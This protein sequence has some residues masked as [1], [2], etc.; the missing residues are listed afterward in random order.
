MITWENLTVQS[1]HMFMK[2]L[3]KDDPQTKCV[4]LRAMCGVF[5]AHPRE[6]L[7]LNQSGMISEVMAPESPPT[8]QLEALL[9]W[10]EILLVSSTIRRG[11]ICAV[12]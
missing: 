8:L 9:C 7:R 11:V 5:M 10:R 1:K 2:F 4:A 12:K 3:A 6:L